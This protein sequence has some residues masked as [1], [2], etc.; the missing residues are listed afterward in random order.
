MKFGQL[1]SEALSGLVN[2]ELWVFWEGGKMN[3]RVPSFLMIQYT[4]AE[5]YLWL[6]NIRVEICYNKITDYIFGYILH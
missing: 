5:S 1:P 3:L 4:N 6:N 2:I